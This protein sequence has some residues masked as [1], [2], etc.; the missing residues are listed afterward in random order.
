MVE[1]SLHCVSGLEWIDK[2][3]WLS[4]GGLRAR[5]QMRADSG[6]AWLPAG[7][8]AGQGRAPGPVR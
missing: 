2:A 6:R 4:E 7:W 8:C 1:G 3:E 5:T